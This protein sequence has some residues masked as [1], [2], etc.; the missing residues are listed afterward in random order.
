MKEN[1]PE[2]RFLLLTD[3]EKEV[4]HLVCQHKSYQQIAD[5][6]FIS[7]STVK[8]HMHNAYAKLGIDDLERDI[9]EHGYEKEYQNGENQKGMKKSAA[10]E[11][12]VTYSKNLFAVMKQLDDMLDIKGAGGGDTFENF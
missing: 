2:N 12:H 7:K 9:S 3:R 4:F 5:E 11:L 6:L 1:T 8:T 10:A